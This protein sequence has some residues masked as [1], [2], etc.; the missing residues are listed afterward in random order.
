MNPESYR[1]RWAGTDHEAAADLVDGRL[2]MRLYT[3]APAD[4]FAEVG[5][6]RF[7]RTVPAADC[8]AVWHVTTVCEW[9]GAPFLVH[10]ARET[11]LLIEYT[12]GNA[13]NAADLGLERIERGVYR[14]WAKRDEVSA[15]SEKVVLIA[16]I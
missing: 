8:S 15:L 7:V 14:I 4:G 5:P 10:A 11:E 16:G 12:G 1:A 9:R 2:F 6:G 3:S 13:L